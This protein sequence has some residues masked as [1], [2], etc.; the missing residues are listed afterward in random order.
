MQVLKR[1]VLA[2]VG[3]HAVAYAVKQAKPKVL[4]VFPI[5]PQTTMLEKLSEYISSE[6]LKAE[7]IKVESEHSALASIYGAALAGARVF[8]ATSSQGLLYMTEMIY[9]AGGQR[10]PIVA[11][12]ATRAIAEPWSIWDDHQDFVSKR[13]AIWIQIMAENVQEAYDMTIQAFR[14][15]E[16][17]RVILP[18][19]MGFDGFI[20]TH[21]MERI[22]VLEDNEVDN[23]LPPRQF[24]LIDFS[25][26]IAIGPIATPE[27]YIKYRYE[28]MKAMERAKG[29]IEE[30]M[31]E[32]ERISGRKQHGLVEC[33][34]CEDAKYV[35]VTMGAW[36]GDG[37]AA[38]DRLRDSGVKT[39]L[40]KIRVFRPFPKEKVEEYL[41][42]MKGVVVFDRAYSY[43]YG[44]I[45]VN[46]IKAALYG[47]RVPVYSVVAGIGGKDVR[48]R[49]FQK[50]IEDLINDNLE[51]E[52]WLF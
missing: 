45:L 20:L 41:R 19:M 43:G 38:V 34:K 46:E 3:N 48:P 51:E 4:A 16:D 29:V 28:A 33:Y 24:N 17:E 36:S 21:T 47:Y 15:S 8:T 10:V 42:S 22:E 11:A 9:W 37:K 32:Y 1:K 40:L 14:I 18:V 25:D 7:L 23:F 50:V 5:T 2:L 6:E 13:D 44:G 39:G 12:V 27:E 49:H 52:R 35:F 30:I 31:G 26:P